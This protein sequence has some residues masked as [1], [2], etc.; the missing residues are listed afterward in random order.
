MRTVVGEHLVAALHGADR[1]LQHR[2]AGV[3]ET[4][5]GL[6]V[7]LLAHHAVAAH[8][9]HLAV[10]IRDDPMAGPQS[11]RHPAPVADGDGVG[12]NVKA[13]APGGLL[14]PGTGLDAGPELLLQGA[15][16]RGSTRRP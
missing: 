10:G 16:W 15:H 3:T 9:L 13:L 7:R 12:E 5:A 4:L 11:R 14:L 2:A 1:G 8:L 6:Q